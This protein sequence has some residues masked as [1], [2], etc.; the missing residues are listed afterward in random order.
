MF[1][2]V[3]QLTQVSL[4][5]VSKIQSFV[6]TSTTLTRSKSPSPVIGI[7]ANTSS[8]ISLLQP[9]SPTVYSDTATFLLKELYWLPISLE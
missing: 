3:K 9:L 2:D 4:H 6:T 8:Q 1:R 5:S 7:T